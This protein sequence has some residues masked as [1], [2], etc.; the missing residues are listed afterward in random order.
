M[1]KLRVL[2]T[3][4]GVVSLHPLH[5]GRIVGHCRK[6]LSV[7]TAVFLFAGAAVAAAVLSTPL[8]GELKE[9]TSGGSVVVADRD[10]RPLREVR[11]E[12][13]TRARWALL[14]DVPAVTTRAILAAEDARFFAHVGVDP[15]AIAR[16]AALDLWNRRVVSGGST[17]TMQL[18]RI[19]HPHP[20][21][22]RGKLGEMVLALRIE[23]SLSKDEILE[24]YL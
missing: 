9:C 12:D 22:L 10:G 23:R 18:A 19:L 15:L 8:P 1:R 17:L 24:Q 16:A 2:F 13:G 21:T 20:R 14:R 5:L 3:K 6:A 7:M 4:I 11:A